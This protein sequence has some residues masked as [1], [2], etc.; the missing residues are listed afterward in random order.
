[1]QMAEEIMADTG[2]L[3]EVKKDHV[4]TRELNEITDDQR[5]NL[6]DSSLEEMTSVGSVGVNT[7][8]S[9]AN[10][11]KNGGNPK[12]VTPRRVSR[13]QRDI[14]K[15]KSNTTEVA[16]TIQPALYPQGNKWVL[17][18]AV[19]TA[20]TSM[21]SLKDHRTVFDNYCDKVISEYK[22]PRV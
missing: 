21:S 5:D 16:P 4:D 17:P 15:D 14:S 2:M 19:K 11:S 7:G 13:D 8:G 20:P 3:S 18:K 12:K 6:I 1:M 9:N 22:K 10:S